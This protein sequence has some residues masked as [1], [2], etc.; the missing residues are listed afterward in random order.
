VQVPIEEI[1]RLQKVLESDYPVELCD[2]PTLGD[3]VQL[4]TDEIVRGVSG[5]AR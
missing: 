4:G 2:V 3:L 1:T 5:R